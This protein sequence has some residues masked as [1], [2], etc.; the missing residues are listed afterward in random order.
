MKRTCVYN[1]SEGMQIQ[2]Q[3]QTILH[4]EHFS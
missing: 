3:I 2:I 4:E 1:E